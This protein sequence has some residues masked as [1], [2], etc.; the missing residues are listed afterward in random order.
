MDPR[1]VSPGPVLPIAAEE[2]PSHPVR[3]V[4]VPAGHPYVR[5][6]TASPDVE[7][8]ADPIRAG[9]PAG[10]WW[11]PVVLDPDWI[12]RSASQADLLHV[13]FGTESF[14]P[15]HLR[16]CFAA[17]RWAGW[18]IVVTVHDLE[19][20]Q[21]DDQERHREQLDVLVGEADALITL[22]PGAAEQIRIRWGRTAAVIPHPGLLARRTAPRVLQSVDRRIGIYVKDLRPNVGAPL[23]VSALGSAV[24]LLAASG[25]D[26]VAEVHLHRHVRD[27]TARDAVRAIVADTDRLVL[28]EH[29]RLDDGQ[30]ENALARLDACV[31]PYRHGSHSGWLELC[32]DL[33]VPVVAPAV[34]FFAEQ[35]PDSS[36]AAFTADASG[37][38]LAA[39]LGSVLGAEASTRA[40]TVQRD[41]EFARRRLLR[42]R[43]DAAAAAEH[44]ALYRRLLAERRA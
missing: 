23:V 17:A 25:V 18:P 21:L 7:V 41:R 11:P 16:S 5:A 19:N 22:T 36:V 33:A 24:G 32:W 4:S 44:A 28:I 8:L 42:A 39:A 37:R 9:D 6:V 2:F 34:G 12:G 1:V 31:L 10:Q 29:D 27:E 38:S 30:L 43:T 40:G 3:V 20:P 14:T 13:H 26:A 35:H 15:E